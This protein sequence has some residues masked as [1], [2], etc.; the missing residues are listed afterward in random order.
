MA[1]TIISLTT[2]PPRMG[3][4]GDTL[5]SL[6]DQ[7]AR[8]DAVMLWIPER[9]RRPEFASFTLPSVPEGIE[10]RRCST[11]YG[12]ATKILPAV[13]TFEGEDVRLIYCDD[14]RL[15]HRGWARN[16]LAHSDANPGACIAEAG[17]VVELMQRK[18]FRDRPAY[19]A[20]RILTAGIYGHF[21]RKR[22][23][24]L[25]PGIGPIDICKGYGG[26]LIRPEFFPPSTFDIPDILWTVDDV[27]L[28]GQLA[29][30][31][32]PILKAAVRENSTKTGLAE[33]SALLDHVEEEHGRHAANAACIRYF[34]ERHGIWKQSLD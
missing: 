19:D 4:L 1:K 28:S 30:N 12:P 21:Y 7:E 33:M 29:L 22:N 10:I 16:L 14:D 17:D 8:I 18:A 15:Y 25:D 32:V 27:W 6:L 13:R 20:L 34:Q 5:R 31:H 23:R 24:A 26:V 9:Y 11:D 3:L 2:I